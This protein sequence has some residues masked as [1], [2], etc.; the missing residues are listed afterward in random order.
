M[1]FPES[2]F[3]AQSAF[4]WKNYS[5]SRRAKGPLLEF[6]VAALEMRGCKVISASEPDR[7]PFYLVFE[8]PGGERH[9]VLAYAFL[10]NMRPTRNRPDDEHRFQIKYGNQLKGILEVAV[11]PHA[12][13]TTIFLGIDPQRRVFVAADPIMNNPSP[14]SRSVEFKA[15][16]VEEILAHGWAAWER[17]RRPAKTKDRPAPIFDEDTRTQVLIGG[18]PDHLLDLIVLERIARGLDPGERHLIADTIL[19]ERPSRTKVK[20]SSHRLI[21]ELGLPEEALFDLIDGASR[22]KMAVRGWVAEQHLADALTR[23]RGVTECRRLNAEG[24]PDIT[25]RWKG[26]A[27]ILIECKNV[28]RKPS[29][30]GQARVDFQRTRA[31]KEDPCSRYYTPAEFAVLAACLHAVTQEWQFTYALTSDLPAHQSCAGRIASMV[32]AS[33]PLF[34]NRPDLV[35]DKCSFREE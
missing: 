2:A 15:E 11:D 13:I 12:L 21:A 26:G 17:D 16:H 7:A 22:L 29:R 24:Q 3:G 14:M 8:T 32:Y 19:L 33:P 28:L 30:R 1:A 31:S 4:G 34:T 18:T 9:G 27:P 25:L 20:K 6:I 35:F 10:A 23:L 5:V